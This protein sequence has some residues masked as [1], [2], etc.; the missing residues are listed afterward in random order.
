MAKIKMQV[1]AG[2]RYRVNNAW[3]GEGEIVEVEKGV[4]SDNLI[5]INQSSKPKVKAKSKPAVKSIDL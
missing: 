2:C 1:K 4:S 5:T 3:C